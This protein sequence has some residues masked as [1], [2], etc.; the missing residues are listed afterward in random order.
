[1]ILNLVTGLIGIVLLCAFTGF[2]LVWVPAPP[3]IVIVIGVTLLLIYDFV[4]T[5]RFGESGP[6]R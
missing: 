2:M 3:L 1:M 4:Q 6:G 5:L